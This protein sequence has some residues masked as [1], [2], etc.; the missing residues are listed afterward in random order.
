MTDIITSD[1]LQIVTDDGL[2]RS[3]ELLDGEFADDGVARDVED[4]LTNGVSQWSI[5]EQ[6]LSDIGTD[7][8][9]LER[10]KDYFDA[11][12]LQASPRA[13]E[14]YVVY[15]VKKLLRQLEVVR[16]SVYPIP[17]VETSERR[18]ME[19]QRADGS[20]VGIEATW[21]ANH[22]RADRTS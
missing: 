3:A 18:V 5:I 8:A 11:R 16:R 20:S 15:V 4:M 1:D 17:V 6:R 19:L 13:D 9:A 2:L 7:D 14:F 21:C 12:A 10:A 22:G